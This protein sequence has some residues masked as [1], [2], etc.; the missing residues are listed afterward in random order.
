MRKSAE[1]FLKLAERGLDREV[2]ESL[3]RTIG[4][5]KTKPTIVRISLTD[6]CNYRCSYCDHWRRDNYPSE[7]SAMEWAKILDSIAALNSSAIIQFVGGEPFLKRDC[8]EIF[9]A[10]KNSGLDWGVI[11]NGYSLTEKNCTE[12]CS[13]KP[14]N[15]DI[16][17]DGNTSRSHDKARGVPGSFGKVTKGISQL[18]EAK[19]KSGENF[20]I[21]L[22]CTVHKLNI[23]EL[24]KMIELV[25]VLGASCIDFTPMRGVD[26]DRLWL[27][28]SEEEIENLGEVVERLC[29]AKSQG[30]PIETP[31]SRLQSIKNHFLN[32]FEARTLETPTE[33]NGCHAPL[34]DMLISPSGGAK[35]CW[36][37]PELGNLTESSAR[38]IWR[39]T[40][41]SKERVTA[42]RCSKSGSNS[43]A[44]TC[45]SHK[46]FSENMTRV[47]NHVFVYR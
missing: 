7:L 20:S 22:K 28:P 42:T 11:T 6:R 13:L 29:L 1:T 24:E 9:S 21:R 47:Y 14:L 2:R 8:F 39:N 30:A 19:T 27:V 18:S 44:T 33:P 17:I 45:V 3:L 26:E 5:D 32:A 23:A 35:F 46:T 43:C 15:V 40:I 36:S 16:S 4:V 34:R 31:L 41:N 25:K 38:N 37:Y 10:A 12:L